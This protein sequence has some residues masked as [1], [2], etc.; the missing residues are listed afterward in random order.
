MQHFKTK[1][2]HFQIYIYFT[3]FI[4]GVMVGIIFPT[5]SDALEHFIAIFIAI[6]M[7]SMFAQIPFFKLKKN[8][9]SLK[10]ILALIL[11]NFV[12][13]PIFVYI[14]ISI[15]NINSTAI[16]IGLL[17]IL[18]IL[19]L[20][21]FLTLFLGKDMLV[22]VDIQPFIK[23]FVTFIIVPLLLALILQLAS[24]ASHMMSR[25]LTATS[26]LPELFMALVLFTVVGSQ[27]NK[28]IND[29][30]IVTTVAPIFII[31]ITIAPF[32][33]FLS[34]KCFHLKTP[35]LRTLAFSASTRNALVILPLALSLPDYW[36][37]ITTTVI[38]TQVLIELLG[39]LIYIKII[40]KLIK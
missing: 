29:L 35:I 5:T 20:P 27:I 33:G 40:P 23:S 11:A 26:W 12:F 19:L 7:F 13:I 15:F 10:Y 16:L 3:A 14:L 18:Q 34:G 6:L 1:I 21:L 28:I 4:L 22:I 2:E 30:S 32:I 25:T 36:V 9:L 39:E 38:I 31:F 24:K 8:V 37:T 17:F